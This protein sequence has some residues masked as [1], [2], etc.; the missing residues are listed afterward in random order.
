K[1]ISLS[2]KTGAKPKSDGTSSG[3]KK[4]VVVKKGAVTGKNDKGN[5]CEF[6]KSA[7]GGIR[8]SDDG[9][10]YNPFAALLKR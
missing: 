10:M 4:V 3:K 5:R 2:L 6:D 8:G 9:T 1:R 7:R